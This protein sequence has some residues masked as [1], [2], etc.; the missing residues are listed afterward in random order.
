[1]DKKLISVSFMKVNKTMRLIITILLGLILST[2]TAFAQAWQVPVNTIPYGKG[3]G[4]AN[5]GSVANTGSGTLCLLNTAPPSFGTC[6]GSLPTLNSGRLFVGNASNVATSVPLSGDCTLVASGAITCTKTNGSAFTAFATSTDAANLTGTV[7]NARLAGTGATTVNGQTC[8]LGS[9]CTVT[10]AASAATVGTTTIGSGTTTR[11]LFDNAGVL[12]E[13]S[14]SG[15]GNVAMTTSPVFTTP[16]IGTPSAGVVTNLTGTAS[17]NINGTVGATTP[18][19]VAATNVAV[20]ATAGALVNTAKF[21]TPSMADDQKNYVSVGNAVTNNNGFYIGYNHNSNATTRVLGIQANESG[22]AS[23]LSLNAS[24]NVGVGIAPSATYRL[25]ADGRFRTTGSS[26][27]SGIDARTTDG[28]YLLYDPDGNGLQLDSSGTGA[29]NGTAVTIKKSNGSVGIGTTT[30]ATQLH[31][32]GTVRFANYPC[33]AGFWGGD[34]S[35]N[36]SCL[37][38][39][40]G[41]TVGATTAATGKFTT[42]ESTGAT[43]IG[44]GGGALK[45]SSTGI[46]GISGCLASDGSSPAVITAG[47]CGTGLPGGGTVGQAVLNTAAG[48]GNWFTQQFYNI[49]ANASTDCTGAVATSI[50][51]VIGSNTNALIPPGCTIKVSAD[52]TIGVTKTLFVQCGATVT[53]DNTKTLTVNARFI[54]PGP[55]NIFQGSGRVQGIRDVRP[56]WFNCDTGTPDYEP[57]INRAIYSAEHAASSAGDT[58][59][60]SFQCS[61]YSYRATLTFTPTSVIPWRGKGCGDGT[62]ILESHSTFTGTSGVVVTNG[63]DTS[64]HWIFEGIEFV[65]KTAGSGASV[66]ITIGGTNAAQIMGG[67]SRS[68]FKNGHVSGY[69]TNVLQQNARMINYDNFSSW[70]TDDSG[71]SVATPVGWKLTANLG[72][73]VGD[74]DWINGSQCASGSNNVTFQGSTSGTTL[75]VAGPLTGTVTIGMKLITHITGTPTILSQ[76]TGSA[77]STG[78]YQMAQNTGVIAA[79]DTLGVY[80]TGDC[81]VLQDDG[82][83][84]IH[85]SGIGFDAPF[86]CYYGATCLKASITAAGSTLDDIWVNPRVQYEGWGNGS[87]IQVTATGSGT[88]A[89]NIHVDGVY[90]AGNGWTKN[91]VLANSSN[92]SSADLFIN[93]NFFA[94]TVYESIDI[95]GTGGTDCRGISATGNIVRF[96]SADGISNSAVYI[97]SCAS[98]TVSGTTLESGGLGIGHASVVVFNTGGDYLTCIGNN[99]GGVTTA[100]GS[101]VCVNSAGAAHF[102][103][104]GNQ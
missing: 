83:N 102:V 23:Q 94:S 89:R 17:I 86:T 45:S 63:S 96:P 2:S 49:S 25:Q 75:T 70:P 66:G 82:S 5:F 32:T 80:G 42:L 69:A 9:T 56:E 33:A 64:V 98:A 55:C 90:F 12:G 77:G 51:T 15:T 60:I 39:L 57:C 38:A 29:L 7:A 19:T 6:A 104:V 20:S 22:I 1:M 31:T 72:G 93:N 79:G 35:G 36:L 50:S 46:G 43:T 92:A 84:A 11:I 24:G 97:E 67:F 87:S 10:A 47:P 103:N 14:I 4:Q 13:Y 76:L 40:N 59:R 41:T 48:T 100:T 78:T 18:S 52:D 101:S 61:P 65:N 88:L 91:F 85:I 53:V 73:F 95:R 26:S 99:S 81:V 71:G 28:Q 30:P 44:S 8:T 62:T 34:G 27:G 68:S 54:D 74:T 3:P 16:N 37:T 21:L 58:F